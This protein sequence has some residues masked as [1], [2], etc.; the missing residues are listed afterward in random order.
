[1]PRVS[2]FVGLLLLVVGT[3]ALAATGTLAACCLRL[4][5]PVAFLLAAYLLAWSWLVVWTFAMSP[6]RLLTRGSL[7]AGLLLGAALASVAWV[8]LG[9]PGP[10]ALGSALR[11]TRDALRDPAILVLA[12]AV[13]LGTLYVVALAFLTPPNDLDVYHLARASLWRQQEGLGHIEGVPDTRVNLFPPNAEIGQLATLVLSGSDRYAAI[14]QFSAYAV[15]SLSVAGLARRIGLRR[16]EALFGALAFAT[17]PLVALEAPSAMNDLVVASFLTAAAYF[18]LGSRRAGLALLSVAIALAIGTKYSA[19]VA[20][21][22]LALVL[23]VGQPRRRWPALVGAGLAGCVAGSIWLVVNLVET[24]GIGTEVPTQ[25]DQTPDLSP[26]PLV[27]TALRLGISFVDMSGA[28]WA[29]S[30]AFLVAAGVLALVGVARH[31]SS[32]ATARPL[33][34]AAAL[35]A[36]VVVVPAIWELIVRVLFKLTLVLGR[37]DVVDRFGWELNTNAE[38]LVAWYGPLGLLL[39]AAG[40]GTVVVLAIRGRL[41]PV[42]AACAVAPLALVGTLALLLAYDVTRGRF[43]VFGVALAAAAWGVGLRFRSIALAAA[44]IGATSLFL[45]LA[46]F[47]GKPSGLFTKTSVWSMARWEALTARNPERYAGVVKYVEERVPEQASVALAIVGEDLIHPFFGRRLTRRISLVRA[48]GGSPPREAEW[49]VIAPEAAARRCRESW[50]TVYRDAEGWR[51][52][53]RRAP[54]DCD[55]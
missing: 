21:P 11:T 22:V 25:P 18:G 19:I 35:T 16:N 29:Y 9:R 27:V 3:S 38:P 26:V 15:L 54:D 23:A 4:A 33:L 7:V 20:L 13:G 12:L 41:R 30:S 34:V 10:P 2:A 17:L 31:R 50:K 43:L 32:R 36:V 39:L 53:Q 37:P 51:V 42:A 44:A 1:M 8:A 24:G 6:A 28:P 52:E 49:L 46:T 45:A 40:S 5:S 14:P 55:L 47:D 48:D